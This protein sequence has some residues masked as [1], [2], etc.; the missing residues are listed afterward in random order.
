M[1]TIQLNPRYASLRT[2]IERIPDTMETEGTY[3]YGGR[4]NLIM[5]M[6]A[7]DG[8]EL[9]VKRFRKPRLLNSIIYSWGLRTPKGQRAWEYP[10]RLLALGVETPEAV[11]YIE[12]RNSL[13]LLQ[14]S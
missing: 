6:T 11:A 10:A 3:I 14:H 4:R 7:P 2:F 9:N 5:K 12:D 1:R 13:G 8:K